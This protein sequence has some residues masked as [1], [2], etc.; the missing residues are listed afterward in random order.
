VVGWAGWDQRDRARAVAGRVLELREQGAADAA[1]LTPL[2]A[3]L[4]EL[5]PWIH[6]WH[7]DPD[8]AYGGTP[9]AFFEAFL[10]QQLSE[11]GLTREVLRDWRPP[12]SARGRKL[13][14]GARSGELDIAGPGAK[15]SPGG[16][17]YTTTRGR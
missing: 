6:Q 12:A 7:P 14:A 3:R 5:L 2:L 13:T 9:G 1:R 8:T 15:L 16:D 17:R 4:L 11:L 10:D